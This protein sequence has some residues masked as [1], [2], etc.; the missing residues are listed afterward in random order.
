MDINNNNKVIEVFKLYVEKAY[1]Y[2]V[3]DSD[4]MYG[5]KCG[6]VETLE[7]LTGVTIDVYFKREDDNIAMFTAIDA[8][9]I[10]NGDCHIIAKGYCHIMH[11]AWGDVVDVVDV[12]YFNL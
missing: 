3:S 8:H 4:Y 10:E 2:E 5:V 9:A 11:T 7:V 6:I 12:D 1:A